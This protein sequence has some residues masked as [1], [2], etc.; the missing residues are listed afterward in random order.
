MTLTFIH[1]PKPKAQTHRHPV[2]SVR[3][4][5][6]VLIEI[7]NLSLLRFMFRE[8]VH[9]SK[10]IGCRSQERRR[11][12]SKMIMDLRILRREYEKRVKDLCPWL[13]AVNQVNR[14]KIYH[15]LHHQIRIYHRFRIHLH[16]FVF[17][18]FLGPRHGR[19]A[20]FYWKLKADG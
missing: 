6:V 17:R 3:K 16:R 13:G 4:L 1:R 20:D 14:L 19:Y 15:H 8:Q 10:R 9:W 2:Q 5:S 18:T 11:V 12:S 7:Q